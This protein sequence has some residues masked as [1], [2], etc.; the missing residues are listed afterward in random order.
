[1]Y[2]KIQGHRPLR[3][4]DVSAPNAYTALRAIKEEEMEAMKKS[5]WRNIRAHTYVRET[6]VGRMKRVVSACANLHDLAEAIYMQTCACA[7][8]YIVRHT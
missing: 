1:V 3:F 5:T 6:M 8:R 2:T 4:G 7:S